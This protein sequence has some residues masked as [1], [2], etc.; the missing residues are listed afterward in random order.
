MSDYAAS[1]LPAAI[2]LNQRLVFDLLATFEDGFTQVTTLTTASNT[3]SSRAD[4]LEGGLGI[5]NVFALLGV[6]LKG[7]TST[8]A[9]A[10]HGIHEAGQRVH[11]P[12]SLFTQLR[13]I[14]QDEGLLK[15]LNGTASF[16][17][18]APGDFV[19]F[20]AVLSKN[21]IVDAFQGF[22][23]L[24]AFASA[25]D[26]KPEPAPAQ[27]PGGGK[28]RTAKPTQ[29]RA[30]KPVSQ[31]IDALLAALS[32]GG[33]ADLLGEVVDSDGLRAVLATETTYFADPSMN[34]IIDGEFHVLGKVTRIVR[35]GTD[36]SINLLRK[37]MFS[38]LPAE[39][40]EQL[41]TVLNNSAS[42]GLRFSTVETAVL[43]PA[44]QV[45]PIAIFA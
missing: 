33:T 22:K 38:R 6:N 28:A 42:M 17:A 31:Q 26:V 25:F 40:I 15:A 30:D 20:R 27:R 16:A 13:A 18:V 8:A 32:G 24:M 45:I 43:G 39:M 10:A 19:E 4:A 3:E 2:Y 35:T 14:L 23:E 36:E 12:V 37:T 34:D 44:F 41:V 7:S 21:P 11:T 1:D 5:S 9:K 29:P